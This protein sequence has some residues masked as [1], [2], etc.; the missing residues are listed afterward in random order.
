MLEIQELCVCQKKKKKK[1]KKK[2]EKER[3]KRKKGKP[4]GSF[5]NVITKWVYKTYI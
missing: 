2:K 1:K 3:K 4:F 5:K